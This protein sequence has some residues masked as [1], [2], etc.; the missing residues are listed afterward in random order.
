MGLCKRCWKIWG[1]RAITAHLSLRLPSGS[2][3]TVF[4]LLLSY[5]SCTSLLGQFVVEEI[6]GPS[7]TGT[8]ACFTQGCPP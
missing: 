4:P 8:T 7:S 3:G 1:M 5:E 6:L 2:S